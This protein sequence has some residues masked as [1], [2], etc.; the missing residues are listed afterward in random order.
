MKNYREDEVDIELRQI[1]REIIGI[2]ENILCD[3]INGEIY[4]RLEDKITN[5]LDKRS[6]QKSKVSLWRQSINR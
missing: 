3:S 2:F 1:A 6:K 4:Y 5:L